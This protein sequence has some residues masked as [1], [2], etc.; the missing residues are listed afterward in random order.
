MFVLD[1]NLVSGLRKMR[2]GEGRPWGCRLG[3]LGTVR[4]ALRLAHDA[5]ER[6]A[7]IGERALR[8]ALTDSTT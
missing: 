8:A 7:E 3:D 6:A 2:S 4:G 1:T 5:H